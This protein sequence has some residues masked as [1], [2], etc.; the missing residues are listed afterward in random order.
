[1]SKLKFKEFSHLLY[2]LVGHLV[3]S[4]SWQQWEEECWPEEERRKLTDTE[5]CHTATIKWVLRQSWGEIE[6][7]SMRPHRLGFQSW[8]LPICLA[9]T[10]NTHMQYTKNGTEKYLLTHRDT[11]THT[12]ITCKDHFTRP[13]WETPST[14]TAG[15]RAMKHIPDCRTWLTHKYRHTYTHLQC[16][17]SEILQPHS[18][19][20]MPYGDVACCRRLSTHEV[21]Q[22]ELQ[23]TRWGRSDCCW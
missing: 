19:T 14:F 5:T 4:S 18:C 12:Q 23:M 10:Q 21:W 15:N 13:Q 8:S 6:S 1:M 17:Y 2:F 16:I 9:K 3:P 7:P 22:E 20:C 11:Y